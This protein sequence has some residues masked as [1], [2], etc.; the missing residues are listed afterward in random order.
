M[1]YKMET[2]EERKVWYIE[3][4]KNL[5]MMSDILARN[6]LKDRECCEYILRIIM[7]D[8]MLTVLDNQVQVDY[9][10]LHGRSAVLDCVAKSGDGRL[11]NVEIQQEN[12]GAI[13]K[14]ARY[15]LGLMDMNVL[16]PGEFF[17]KLPE[18]YIIF[19]TQDDTL[20][21][22]LPIAH[23]DRIIKENGAEF[24]DEAHII[25]VDSSKHEDTELGRLM[26]DFHCK[27]ASDMQDGALAKRI[28]ELKESE[29]GVEYMCKEMEE[30]RSEGIAVG[31][32]VGRVEGRM[33]GKV[34]AQRE[35]AK[36]LLDLGMP[37]EQVAQVAKVS[38]QLIQEWFSG[39]TS[40]VK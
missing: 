36:R 7:N 8:S 5:T 33:E 32:E 2:F 25:Y 31:L 6:V 28:F 38:V 19:V 12:E 24:G 15:H 27:A 20:G 4:I 21:Y 34:E 17:D 10:N 18:T 35:M 26:H 14:R 16:N 22:K 13:P 29:K 39:E 40:P 37:V 23:V 30:I 1:S 9:K 11:F 3:K